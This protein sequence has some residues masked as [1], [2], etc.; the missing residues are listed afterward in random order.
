MI[1]WKDIVDP[2]LEISFEDEEMAGVVFTLLFQQLSMD[3][4]GR[5]RKLKKTL[6]TLL[7]RSK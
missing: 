2:L 5:L 4:G 6:I 7:Q 3:S 1:K